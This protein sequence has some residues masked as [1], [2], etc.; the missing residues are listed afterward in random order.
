MAHREVDGMGNDRI[1][2][3]LTIVRRL[4]APR[5]QLKGNTLSTA[6]MKSFATQGHIVKGMALPQFECKSGRRTYLLVAIDGYE[7]IE[8]ERRGIQYL[9]DDE[10]SEEGLREG[11]TPPSSTERRDPPEV[12]PD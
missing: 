8:A 1:E 11:S 12:I 7:V 2:L 6:I 3:K 5:A 4:G 10:P 9:L